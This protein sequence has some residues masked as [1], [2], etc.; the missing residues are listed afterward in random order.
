MRTGR[1]GWAAAVPI[2]DPFLQWSGLGPSR[3]GSSAIGARDEFIAL[4][5]LRHHG[6]PDKAGMLNAPACSAYPC[7]DVS[8]D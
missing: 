8:V 7:R 2:G 3:H 1:Q 6:P 4:A 5:V